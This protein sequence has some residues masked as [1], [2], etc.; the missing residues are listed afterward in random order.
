[1]RQKIVAGN[2]KMNKRAEQA[3]GLMK[4]LD[5]QTKFADV[6]GV[7][8]VIA[9]PV[10][11]AALAAEMFE[12]NTL[13][14]IGAQNASAYA[15]GAYTGEVSAEMLASVGV[16]Y[17][18]VGHSERRAHFHETDEVFLMKT[19]QLLAQNIRPIFC[20]GE[21]LEARKDGSYL[22][23]IK[24][25][26]ENSVFK[27]TKEEMSKV[28]LAYEPVWAIG[29]GETAS[30]EQAQEV[31]AAIR[32]WLAAKFDKDLANN[33][34]ILYGGSCKASN[35]DELFACA[36]I[37]GGLIGGAS[38]DAKEFVEIIKALGKA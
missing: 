14:A 10:L 16:D 25:Q 33:C 12:Y 2:W 32:S 28:I 17:C 3:Y 21:E 27:L 31:H 18:L 5:R 22:K 19:K 23:V 1:M 35:A 11:Y 8:I 20:V 29:T 30:P 37:D 26:L 7:G 34:T 9:P 15:E 4:E 36:D 6:P 38:L 24:T 13:V